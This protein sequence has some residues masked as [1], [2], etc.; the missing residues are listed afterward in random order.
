MTGDRS[1][2]VIIH[3]GVPG[4]GLK[5]LADGSGGYP[6]TAVDMVKLFREANVEADYDR[7][8][9]ERT[10]VT[11]HAADIWLPILEI[12]RDIGISVFAACVYDLAKDPRSKVHAKV[13]RRRNG[14]TTWIEVSG[15]RED[16]I[17]AVDE[18]L[19]DAG[20]QPVEGEDGEG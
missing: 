12:V 9:N 6:S 19:S 13:G 5:T 2:D 17:R 4:I 15:D 7:P 10:E 8:P 16:V 11:H 20:D 1:P 18:F 14:E 3:A